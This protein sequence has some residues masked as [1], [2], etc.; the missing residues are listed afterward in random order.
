MDNFCT[1]SGGFAFEIGR[2]FA[3]VSLFVGFFAIVFVTC[4][5]SVFVAPLLRKKENGDG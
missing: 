1:I 3:G 4:L 2:F 5:I